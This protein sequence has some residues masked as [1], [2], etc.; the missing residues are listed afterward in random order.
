M[1]AQIK[2]LTKVFSSKHR[3]HEF[4]RLVYY[5]TLKERVAKR[6]QPRDLFK[7]FEK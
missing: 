4:N 3:L 6:T 2:D 1:K 7:T 5:N